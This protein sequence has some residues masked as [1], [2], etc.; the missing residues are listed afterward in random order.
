MA[1]EGGGGGGRFAKKGRVSD[2]PSPRW[3]PLPP[4]DYIRLRGQTY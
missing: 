2:H 4:L 1:R 3:N